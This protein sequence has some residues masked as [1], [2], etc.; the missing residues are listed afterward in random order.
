ME[1]TSPPKTNWRKKKENFDTLKK[2]NRT[3]VENFKNIPM[4]DVLGPNTN[5]NTYSSFHTEKM[6]NDD[7]KEGFKEGADFDMFGDDY[8]KNVPRGF[9]FS[10]SLKMG[11]FFKKIF[12]GS[13]MDK[14]DKHFDKFI[15]TILYD[16]LLLKEKPC[17]ENDN[18]KSLEQELTDEKNDKSFFWYSGKL[19][20]LLSKSPKKE[21]FDNQE[22]FLN[23][24]NSFSSN[25]PEFVKNIY[26]KRKLSKYYLDSLNEYETHNQGVLSHEELLLFNNDFDNKLN[27]TN[28]Q[29]KIINIP[30]SKVKPKNSN[31]VTNYENTMNDFILYYN[32]KARFK[33]NNEDEIIYY[34]P[35]CNDTNTNPLGCPTYSNPPAYIAPTDGNEPNV[36]NTNYAFFIDTDI[37]DLSKSSIQG[38]LNDMIKNFSFVLTQ[39]YNNE[40]K[41]T[42]SELLVRVGT[43]YINFLNYIEFQN[44]RIYNLYLNEY[45]IAAFNH[46]FYI[47]L[48]QDNPDISITSLYQNI[49]SLVSGFY[50]NVNTAVES[51]V[52]NSNASINNLMDGVNGTNN[53][54][55]SSTVNNN[56]KTKSTKDGKKENAYVD[57]GGIQT[58]NTSYYVLLNEIN[59][60]S[61]FLYKLTEYKGEL[62]DISSNDYH[63]NYIQ[64]PTDGFPLYNEPDDPTLNEYITKS[65]FTWNTELQSFYLQLNECEKAKLKKKEEL[66]RYV[67]TIKKELYRMLM[68]PICFYITYNFYYMFFFKD[69]KDKIKTFDENTNEIKYINECNRCF[70]PTFP[71][72]ETYF[73]H[74]EDHYTD[75]FFEFI[76][77]P[78]K[79]FYTLANAIKAIFRQDFR[80]NKQHIPKDEIPYIFLLFCFVAVYMIFFHKTAFVMKVFNG[81]IT[82]NYDLLLNEGIYRFSQTITYLCFLDTLMDKMIGY[83]ILKIMKR[84]FKNT[85]LNPPNA[86]EEA[87][88]P[89]EDTWFNWIGTTTNPFILV[90]KIIFTLIYWLIKYVITQQLLPL[91]VYIIYFYFLFNLL[92]GIY[93]NTDEN[94]GLFD[95]IELIS[96]IFYTKFYNVTE[97]S[98]TMYFIKIIF[99]FAYTFMYEIILFSIL[100]AG[101]KNYAKY[102]EDQ[103]IKNVLFFTYLILIIAVC[104]WGIYKYKFFVR[105]TLSEEYNEQNDENNGYNPPEGI[106]NKR[107]EINKFFD[108]KD[109]HEER[110]GNS[111]FSIFMGSD[112]INQEA[113]NEYFKEKQEKYEKQK[114]DAM[115]PTKQQKSGFA[116]FSD[117][118]MSGFEKAGNLF[119]EKSSEYSEK[120]KDLSN[121]LSEVAPDP[122]AIASN[123]KKGILELP[124]KA[125]RK[126]NNIKESSKNGINKVKNLFGYRT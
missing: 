93:N 119:K 103:D 41:I 121:K 66:E 6:I 92:F 47:L 80:I 70:N 38:Y 26:V 4:F 20:E 12:G 25:H 71:D 50:K 39:K 40:I 111:F 99:W 117:K 100:I 68:V 82:M 105:N 123:I 78:V 60:R 34:Y 42:P 83:S 10:N 62:T 79:F 54:S 87:E 122:I 115:D 32:E 90:F 73:H 64:L 65:K 28:I 88:P 51:N 48:F 63:Y 31:L 110:S 7:Y 49:M 27:D 19:S 74:Y 3:N 77:K 94:A 67:P 116:K 97:S 8:F 125:E 58:V 109:L 43:V 61:S 98:S 57:I 55:A 112:S 86:K 107:I 23:T 69:C 44:Y 72:W 35:T 101:L 11:E 52:T 102:I 96:R 15:F 22:M 24:I 46:V 104:A 81:I 126:Y 114:A 108:C 14:L 118:F 29:K 2:S 13:P 113:M 17:K 85:F 36:F 89:N 91:A 106:K 30:L 76:F 33:I 9:K 124:Y 53:A 1:N 18:L 84:M 75:Y 56:Y 37:T 59:K 45:Q 95:K 5:P 16:M 21:G 120:A